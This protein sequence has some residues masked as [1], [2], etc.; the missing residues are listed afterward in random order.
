MHKEFA[1][2]DHCVGRQFCLFKF[3]SHPFE[4][5]LIALLNMD[6][7][8]GLTNYFPIYLFLFWVQ[9]ITRHR[10]FLI[11]LYFAELGVAS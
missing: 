3:L 5:I 6:S 9:D 11:I 1:L 7:L 10:C 4:V 8:T 2:L